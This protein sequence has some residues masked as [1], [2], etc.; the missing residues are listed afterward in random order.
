[1]GYDLAEL[2]ATYRAK[3]DAAALPP[4][5]AASA[6]AALEAGLTGYTYLH[7]EHASGGQA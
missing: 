2:R 6:L 4:G 5:E 7:E 1:V 3:V